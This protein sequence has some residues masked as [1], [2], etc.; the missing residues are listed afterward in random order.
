MTSIWLFV[1]RDKRM[2][3]RR[4]QRCHC[5]PYAAGSHPIKP[6]LPGRLDDVGTVVVSDRD[7]AGAPQFLAMLPALAGTQA[8][9]INAPC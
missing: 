4:R 3:G 1:K 5:L 7:F 2:V 6:R 8:N 9:G